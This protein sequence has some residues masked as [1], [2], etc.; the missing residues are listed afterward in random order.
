[1]PVAWDPRPGTEHT[2]TMLSK[3]YPRAT[4][5]VFGNF[6]AEIA[7]VVAPVLVSVNRRQAL[8]GMQLLLI[9]FLDGL[10]FT[11]E[12]WKQVL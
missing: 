5:A 8:S 10:G 11:V 6:F 9:H 7:F 1:M 3:R 4:I 12:H 2:L